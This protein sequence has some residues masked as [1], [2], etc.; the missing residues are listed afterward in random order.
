MRAKKPKQPRPPSTAPSAW[1]ILASTPPAMI[2]LMARR[3]IRGKH[4]RAVSFE[5]LAIASGIA[6]PRLREII[7]STSWDGI[8]IPEAERFIAACGF[9]PLNPQDRNRKKSYEL[10]CQKRPPEKRFMYLRKSPWWEK[11]FLPL[12]RLLT[13]PKAS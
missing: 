9:D 2:R 10:I 6:P 5:E 12:I 1:R 13:L 3:R 7:M 11:E 8:T 4:V